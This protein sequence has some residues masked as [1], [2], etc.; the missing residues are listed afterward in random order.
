MTSKRAKV[1]DV[2]RLARV[3]AATVSRV[4]NG[5]D[6]AHFTP[7]TADRVVAAARKLNYRPSELGRSLRTSTSRAA[8]LLVPT[9]VGLSAELAD[10]LEPVLYRN[11][12]SMLLCNT[13]GIPERQD[14]YLAQVESRGVSA[15]VLSGVVKSPNL[16]RLSTMRTPV[17]FVNRR[18]P[19]PIK[20]DFVGIDYRAAGRDVADYFVAKGFHDCAVIQ[21]LQAD[22]ASVERLAGFVER[23]REEGITLPM[24]RRIK[25]PLTPEAGYSRGKLLLSGPRRPR[26]V[27]CGNNS[28]AY[29]LYRVCAEMRLRIP[30]DVA[31]FGFDDN[32]MN[33]WLAPWLSSVR[34]PV[35][36]FGPAVAKI[37]TDRS[38]EDR[39]GPQTVIL[40]HKLVLRESA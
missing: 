27:F 39:R 2:A 6:L 1:D 40:P 9:T 37:L 31:I 30:D 10:S 11:G 29:G 15:I 21:G 7:E 38:S 8:A 20:G 22:G 36:D 13:G 26:A 35:Q 18:P 28:V 24:A 17:V 16:L 23:L 14:E 25:S 32:R 5:K 19:K 12:L 4:L 34:I 33:R 3:S